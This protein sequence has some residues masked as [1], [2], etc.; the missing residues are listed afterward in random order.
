MAFIATDVIVGF[1]GETDE[2]FN[3]TYN[4]LRDSPLSKFHIFRFSP[5]ENT[6]AYFLRKKYKEP[7]P[8]T[9][10]KRA[11]ILAALGQ[12]KYQQ[13]LEKHTDKSFPALFLQKRVN[14]FQEA[15][16]D[17][18][19]PVFIKTCHNLTGEIKSVKIETIRK[20]GLIGKIK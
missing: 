7:R 4:F 15:L 20:E 6:A 3:E 12:N 9:K 10:A 5:R 19:I 2:D 1:P 17:N 11:K 13:F 16:L 18:Q 14:G 8:Q